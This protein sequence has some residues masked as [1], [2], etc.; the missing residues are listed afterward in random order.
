MKN[1][2]IAYRY[3]SNGYLN[4]D[5]LWQQTADGYGVIPLTTNKAPWGKGERDSA[6][7]YRYDGEKWLTVP[8][9]THP[10]ELKGVTVR[11]DDDTEHADELRALMHSFEGEQYTVVNNDGVLSLQPVPVITVSEEEQKLQA[12]LRELD[13][14]TKVLKDRLALAILQ[15][16]EEEVAKIRAEYAALF[17]DE[18]E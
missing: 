10:D 17:T 2:C 8:K 16:D 3:D 11:A 6:F 14:K 7:F 13:E 12:Q 4:G 15:D 9:P 1:F 18:E 5:T